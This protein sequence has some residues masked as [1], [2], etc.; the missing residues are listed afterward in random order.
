MIFHDKNCL[1]FFNTNEEKSKSSEP[2]DDWRDKTTE[3]SKGT[4]NTLLR[5]IEN[6][7]S[8]RSKDNPN[9]S[10]SEEST[11]DVD[12]R[13]IL[14]EK[15]SES[16]SEG[17][18][19]FYQEFNDVFHIPYC[20]S[21]YLNRIV[22]PKTF[23]KASKDIRK[24]VGSKWVYKVKYKSTGEGK[25]FK[26]SK[27]QSMLSKS[28]YETEYSAMNS[29]TCE[30]I[31]ILKILIE[32]NIKTSALVPLH[33]YNSFAI[34]IAAN[35]VFYEKT[36]HFE[37][38]LFFLREYVLASVVKTVTDFWCNASDETGVKHGSKHPNSAIDHNAK[39][40][41]QSMQGKRSRT[42]QNEDS[43]GYS[44]NTDTTTNPPQDD[45]N[46]PHHPLYFHPND[47][48]GL[49]LIVKKLNGSDNYG[50]WKRSMLIALSAKNKLKLINGEYDEPT[51]DSPRA[52]NGFT[53]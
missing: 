35:H 33:C 38:E 53:T 9:D 24:P 21:K 43:N 48:P 3:I 31:W 15:D 41:I 4:D 22:E 39:H 14:E 2:Y 23:D 29:V 26:A 11:S 19:S 49:L 30:V 5:R 32:L 16:D 51:M 34:Q 20:D 46:S 10:T 12:D 27:K 47:H 25:R 13:A 40:F 44:Q 17:D 52:N 42:L 50:T 45:I 37:M 28:S 18:D 8:I 6:S 1:N 36:K 7:K